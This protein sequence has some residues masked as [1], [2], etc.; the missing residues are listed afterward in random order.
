MGEI[1]SGGPGE[2]DYETWKLEWSRYLGIRGQ[3]RL[4]FRVPQVNN[5]V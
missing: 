3:I 4:G 5:P 1:N 2:K